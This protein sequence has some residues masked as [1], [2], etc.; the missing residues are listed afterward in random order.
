V[1]VVG[2]SD[3]LCVL[4]ADACAAADLDVVG[5]PVTLRPD[6]TPHDLSV[7]LAAVL[8]D[9]AVDSVVVAHV[10]VLGTDGTPWEVVVAESVSRGSKPVVAVLVAADEESGLIDREGAG[11]DAAG[12]TGLDEHPPVAFYGTVEDAVRALRRVTRHAEWRARPAGEIPE[13][14]DIAPEKARAVVDRLVGAA[15]EDTVTDLPAVRPGRPVTDDVEIYAEQPDDELMHVLAAYGI[16]V[17]PVVP[18]TTEVEA[19]AAADAAGYPVVLKTLDPRFAQ[20]TDLGGLRL[21]LENERAVRTA[22][23]SMS[24]SLDPDAAGSLVV[25][26]MATPGVACV[27]ASTEDALFGPV[28]SFGIAGVVPELL[29][30]RGYRIPPLTDAEAREL[31]D[32]PGAAPLLHGFGGT[33][34]VDRG[35]LEDLLVRVGLLADDLPELAE[36]RLEPVVVAES[37]LAVLGA[38]AVLRRPAVR[39]GIEARRLGD[40]P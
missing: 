1:A 3:A 38:R 17:W 32:A 24:A 31:V 23:L 27:V 19:V 35:A 5:E 8:E 39:A 16:H 26:R 20:R 11:A 30:D 21:N 2:N 13:Y 9:P 7:A 15:L 14:D 18:V 34:P 33:P 10:P 6:C 25:Q 29:G 12:S 22:F 36:L 40:T 28:V 37:G 4:A